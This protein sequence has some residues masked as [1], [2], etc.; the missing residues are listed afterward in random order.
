MVTSPAHLLLLS[1]ILRDGSEVNTLV[2][3][4]V[5]EIIRQAIELRG[6]H[7]HEGNRN[8]LRGPLG[9][10]TYRRRLACSR[11]VVPHLIRMLGRLRPVLPLCTI[12][13]LGNLFGVPAVRSPVWKAVRIFRGEDF[14]AF[15][16]MICT[17]S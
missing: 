5:T 14:D 1:G 8:S 11:I 17:R 2:Y 4:E 7:R 15:D 10:A 16:S 12:D 9:V 13:L 6:G 3:V